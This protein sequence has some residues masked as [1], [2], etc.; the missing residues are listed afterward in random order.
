VE[1]RLFEFELFWPRIMEMT[2]QPMHGVCKA[3][4]PLNFDSMRFRLP[5]LAFLLAAVSA[6]EPSAPPGPSYPA[7]QTYAASLGIDL[8][9]FVKVDTNLYYTRTSSSGRARS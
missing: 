5:A 4:T 6:C 9:T 1:S 3:C 7:E 8:S 2:L